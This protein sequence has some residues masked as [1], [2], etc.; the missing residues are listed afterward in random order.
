MLMVGVAVYVGYDLYKFPPGSAAGHA[1]LMKQYGPV[2]A[3]N[4]LIALLV[5]SFSLS[6]GALF[7]NPPIV[8]CLCGFRAWWQREK[9]FCLA[10]LAAM[11]IFILFI[12]F[13][14]FFKGDPAWGPRYLTPIFAV[15]WIFAP[16]GSQILRRWVVTVVLALGLVV[17][18]GAL[19]IDP[20]RLYIERSLPSSFYLTAPGLYFHP[21]ISHLINR[22]REITEVIASQPYRAEYY[23]PSS[24]PTFAFPVIDFV[25]RGPTAVQKYHVL[26]GFRFWWASFPYL[27]QSLQPVDLMRSVI[28]LIG[29]AVTGLILL[30]FGIV[31]S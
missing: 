19:C 27:E 12:S 3:T 24:V 21:A 6:A 31:R 17:Q 11:A 10:L 30:V 1:D 22:P 15:L 5:M 16:I 29:V 8:I 28:L 26:S 20:H 4:P 25:E 18:V 23:S 7:Y 9:L 14:T 13:L 2:W